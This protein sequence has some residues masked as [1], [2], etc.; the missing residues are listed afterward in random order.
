MRIQEEKGLDP[1]L[2][3]SIDWYSAIK[4]IEPE[5]DAIIDGIFEIFMLHKWEWSKG[6]IFKRIG[7]V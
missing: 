1:Y 2:I 5:F 7:R 6:E 3:F 4:R